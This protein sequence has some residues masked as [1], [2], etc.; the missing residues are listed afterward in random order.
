LRT[1]IVY[2]DPGFLSFICKEK[3][4]SFNDST[5]KKEELLFIDKLIGLGSIYFN[6]DETVLYD[7]IV[8]QEYKNN[9]FYDEDFYHYAKMIIGSN[10]K[11]Y[12]CKDE[13]NKIVKEL[14]SHDYSESQ[15]PL[16][17]LTEKDDESVLKLNKHTGC[18]V[19]NRSLEFQKYEHSVQLNNVVVNEMVNEFK[20]TRNL[21][22]PYSL[23]IEDPYIYSINIDFFHSLL[24]NLLK[25]DLSSF[26]PFRIY[27]VT[28]NPAHQ[29]Y[30]NENNIK[31][32]EKFDKKIKEL[33]KTGFYSI[34][35]E[36]WQ[37]QKK[38]PKMHD[39]NIFTEKFW[40]SCTHSFKHKYDTNVEWVFKPIAIYFQQYLSRIRFATNRMNHAKN[41]PLIKR[42]K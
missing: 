22:I 4:K 35:V 5:L 28:M 40:I 17:Y 19:I 34:K 26:K 14:Y 9:S 37:N 11:T 12:S 29:K 21:S 15:T 27:I 10:G 39:R 2:I 16:Y 25:K 3:R 1:F 6:I 36:N 30:T 24:D 8:A 7:L 42:Y 32:Y 18:I 23:I 31:S 13:I 33:N 38:Q 20:L 41:H